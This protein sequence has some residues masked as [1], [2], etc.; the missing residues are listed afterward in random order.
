MNTKVKEFDA[1]DYLDNEEVIAA[2]LQDAL[3]DGDPN[4]FLLAVADVVKARSMTRLSQDSGLGRESLY[5]TIKPGA[6]PG[7][8]TVTRL[9]G[10]LGV[11]LQAVP[12]TRAAAAR[13]ATPAQKVAAKQGA[14]RTRKAKPAKPV[15]AKA[16]KKRTT[17]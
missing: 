12:A 10:A 9:L 8:A 11:K 1:A 4:V 16:A 17:R 5:K 2:Y 15:A 13:T 14:A 7:F 3:E 6:R